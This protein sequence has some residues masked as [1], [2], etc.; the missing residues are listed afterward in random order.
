MVDIDYFEH[1]MRLVIPVLFLLALPI[2]GADKSKA[3][4]RLDTLTPPRRGTTDTWNKIADVLQTGEMP[5]KKEPRPASS[6]LAHMIN[7]IGGQLANVQAPV[8]GL[9]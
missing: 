4:L 2:P 3:D 6:D 1:R 8:L 5:P 7:W 9:R